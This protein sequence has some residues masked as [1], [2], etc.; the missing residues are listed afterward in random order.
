A[1][2]WVVTFRKDNYIEIKNRFIKE[3]IAPNILGMGAKDAIFILENSGLKVVLSGRGI[4]QKQSIEPGSAIR[5]GQT[6]YIEL[7]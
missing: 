7:G 3:G 6:I 1:S 4:V 5:K 2:D